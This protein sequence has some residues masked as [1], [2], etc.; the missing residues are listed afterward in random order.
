M[1]R[2]VVVR[3]PHDP[4]F[5]FFFQAEDGIRDLTVTGVQTC[6]LPILVW[7]DARCSD[8]TPPEPIPSPSRYRGLTVPRLS[9]PTP[10]IAGLRNSRGPRAQQR[11]GGYSSR[12]LAD[13][14][15]VSGI[16]TQ[17][18][19][20]G[21]RFDPFERPLRGRDFRGTRQP[22]GIPCPRVRLC[23]RRDVLPSLRQ[24]AGKDRVILVGG[25]MPRAWHAHRRA[26]AQHLAVQSPDD[27]QT[28]QLATARR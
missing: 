6:A 9:Q 8:V 23:K 17:L 19:R 27:T 15:L 13:M 2:M 3:E 18:S 10:G 7:T 22:R 25:L 12:S 26:G 1:E 11:D 21:G 14:E 16:I 20:A 4:D 24:P 28:C 5:R